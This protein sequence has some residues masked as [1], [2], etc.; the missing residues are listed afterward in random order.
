MTA[1]D[2]SLKRQIPLAP[3]APSIHGTE[4]GLEDREYCRVSGYQQPIS[5]RCPGCT[6]HFLNGRVD[7]PLDA[8]VE[9][10]HLQSLNCAQSSRELEREAGRMAKGK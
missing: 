6:S 3:R 2:H 7:G 8:E 5:C 1:P 9:A 10:L 4:Q